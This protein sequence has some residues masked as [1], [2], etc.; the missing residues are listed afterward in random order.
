MCQHPLLSLLLPQPLQR[1]LQ[2]TQSRRTLLQRTLSLLASLD[3]PGLITTTATASSSVPPGA[4]LFGKH[5]APGLHTAGKLGFV[6]LRKKCQ[7]A[8]MQGLQPSLEAIANLD[9]RATTEDGRE[10]DFA[11]ICDP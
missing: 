6:S 10:D 4:S 9:P 7:V 1:T 5:A 3:T 8:L 11:V 2:R